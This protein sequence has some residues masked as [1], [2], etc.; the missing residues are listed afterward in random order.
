[1]K[2]TKIMGYVFTTIHVN[3]V[4][5]QPWLIVRPTGDKNYRQ[6]KYPIVGWMVVCFAHHLM[7][8]YHQNTIQASL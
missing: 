1:M 3:Y 2:A 6:L 5:V 4:V 8:K 7:S